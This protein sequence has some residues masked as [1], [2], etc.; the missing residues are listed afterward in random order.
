MAFTHLDP[1]S[2]TYH[3]RQSVHFSNEPCPPSRACEEHPYLP[4]HSVGFCANA[5]GLA[6]HLARKLDKECSL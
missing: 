3:D 6:A 1:S 5:E 4:V 2:Q